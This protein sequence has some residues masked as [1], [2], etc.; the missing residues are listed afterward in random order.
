MIDGVDVHNSHERPESSTTKP[1][2][3]VFDVLKVAEKYG[4]RSE[5]LKKCNNAFLLITGI[6]TVFERS[7]DISALENTELEKK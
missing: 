3:H 6:T 2:G 7:C 1:C 5:L 4:P